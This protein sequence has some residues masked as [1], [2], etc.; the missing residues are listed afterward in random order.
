MKKNVITLHAVALLSLST[1]VV[2]QNEIELSSNTPL[3]FT[4]TGAGMYNRTVVYHATTGLYFD[5]A[6][7]MD[8]TNG[9]PIDFGIE[10][11]GGTKL[12][13]IKGVNGFVGIGTNSTTD[14]LSV[15]GKIRAQELKIEADNGTNWPDYVFQP[16]YKLTPLPELEKFIKTNQHLPEVPSAK[17]VTANGIEVGANQALLLK[18][19]EEITLH[20]IELNKKVE[21]L[22]QENKELKKRKRKR[23]LW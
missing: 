6:K 5:L 7:N 23:L 20:L 9:V 16:S 2:A 11:R 8:N 21:E 12:F 18:K 14:K 4:S 19:I 15:K 1:S 17:E 10:A 3:Q 13:M 22:Q